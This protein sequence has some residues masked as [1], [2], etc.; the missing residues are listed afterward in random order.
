MDLNV[1]TLKQLGIDPDQI[2]EE[3]VFTAAKLIVD[4]VSYDLKKDILK[5]AEISISKKI[6]E[7]VEETLSG[8]YQPIDDYG[9]P[10]GKATSLREHFKQACVQWW[11]TAVD[12]EGKPCTGWVGTRRYEWIAKKVVYDVLTTN[13]KVDFAKLVTDTKESLKTGICNLI[14]AEMERVWNKK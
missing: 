6:N 11:E 14:S 10:I 2:R 4:Q 1:E 7:L 9:E 12:N 5:N 8:K 13:I 3:I